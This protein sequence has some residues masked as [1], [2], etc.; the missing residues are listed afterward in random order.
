M[1]SESNSTDI[2]SGFSFEKRRELVSY[3][4]QLPEKMKIKVHADQIFFIKKI[5]ARAAKEN[6]SF[7]NLHFSTFLM[8]IEKLKLLE[9]GLTRKSDLTPDEKSLLDKLRAIRTKDVSR[10]KRKPKKADSLEKY[11]GLVETLRGQGLSWKKISYFLAR[12]HRTK[13]DF[14]YMK[15]TFKERWNIC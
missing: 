1:I 13:I 12:Y 7:A 6:V 8:S 4:S 9:S 14:D 2:L 11:R 3:Y 10:P 15:K 5:K